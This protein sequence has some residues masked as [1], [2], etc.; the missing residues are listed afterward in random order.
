MAEQPKAETKHSE[1]GKGDI[2]FKQGSRGG[3]LYFIKEGQVELIVRDQA[4]MAEKVVAQVGENSVLGTMTFL[5]GEARSATAKCLTPVKAIVVGQIQREKLLAQVPV[6]FKVLLKDMATN[7][8][9]LNEE[10]VR[11]MAKH[12]VLEKRVTLMKT[13]FKELSGKGGV[14]AEV[15]K[16][17]GL[18]DPEAKPETKSEAKPES[19]PEATPETKAAATP[20]TKAAATP[21]EAT[22]A[23]PVDLDDEKE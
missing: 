9:H 1:F 23:V 21:K 12:E 13:R 3:E 16:E 6:W 22:A 19:K 10:H 8:R 4:T 11:L 7:L 20:E 18:D 15:A 2:L 5:E 17:L 14:S